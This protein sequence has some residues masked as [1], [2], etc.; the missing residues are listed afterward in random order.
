[1]KI[2]SHS[3][4]AEGVKWERGEKPRRDYSDLSG[5]WSQNKRGAQFVPVTE[6]R[7]GLVGKA[8]VA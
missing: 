2:Y 7:E 4:I 6:I 8:I 3:C 1:M 5:G